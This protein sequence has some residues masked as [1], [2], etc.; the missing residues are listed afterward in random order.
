VIGARARCLQFGR[1]VAKGLRLADVDFLA[2]SVPVEPALASGRVPPLTGATGA[3]SDQGEL[4]A[5][6]LPSGTIVHGKFRVIG[7][8]PRTGD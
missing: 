1:S 8:R 6:A 7:V 5:S 3:P 2:G 4:L